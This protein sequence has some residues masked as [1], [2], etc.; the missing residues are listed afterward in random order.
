MAVLQTVNNGNRKLDAAMNCSE[1][2]EK[3]K[4]HISPCKHPL[5]DKKL[6]LQVNEFV[7]L[8]WKTQN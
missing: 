1:Q 5:L 8:S 4:R 2:N 3:K 6:L 7:D